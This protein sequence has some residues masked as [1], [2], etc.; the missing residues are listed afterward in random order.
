ME[1]WARDLAAIQ[2]RDH[3]AHEAGPRAAHVQNRGDAVGQEHRHVAAAGRVDV[4]IGQPRRQELRSVAV[5]HSGAG[6]GLDPLGDR[7]DH[8]IAH[9]HR[10][11]AQHPFAVHRHDVDMGE[12]HD[13]R[14]RRLGRLT[15][16]AGQGKEGAGNQ[17]RPSGTEHRRALTSNDRQPVH[18]G[19]S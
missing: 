7:F 13:R 12:Q 11:V 16:G 10:A 18:R 14:W 2:A 15:G 6:R 19:P 1:V 17:G 8:A 5:D 3:L 9:Q 4:H